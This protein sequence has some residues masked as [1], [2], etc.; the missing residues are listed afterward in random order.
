MAVTKNADL[1]Q[2]LVELRI[3]EKVEAGFTTRPIFLT[4]VTANQDA[5]NYLQ[6]ARAAGH[7]IDLLDLDRLIPVLEQLKRDWFV[8]DEVRL[9]IDPQRLFYVGGSRRE[10]N[11]L[12]VAVRARQLVHLPGID[13]S[14][15]FAQNVRLGLGGTRVNDDI[16]ESVSDVVQRL[17]PLHL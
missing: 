14:R 10:P 17:L 6:Q 16:L 11:L 1:Q 15:V 4:N 5:A 8:P 9:A 2:L 3:G 13:D 7:E 12:Y